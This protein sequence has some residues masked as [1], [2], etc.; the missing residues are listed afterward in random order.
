M[1]V[2]LA[3]SALMQTRRLDGLCSVVSENATL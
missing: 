1:L 3:A 2:F